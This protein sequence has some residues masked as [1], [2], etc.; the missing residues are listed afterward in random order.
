MVWIPSE[1]FSDPLVD[2]HEGIC[3]QRGMLQR[4]DSPR[5]DG[6]MCRMKSA[7]RKVEFGTAYYPDHWPEAQW[8]RDLDLIQRIGIEVVRFGEFSWS[9][10]EPRPGQ[11]D[12]SG[13]DRFMKLIESRRL[14]LML[15]TPTATLPPW[16]PKLHPDCRLMDVDGH[17]CLSHRHFWCWNHRESRAL[18]ETTIRTLVHRYQDHPS[19]IGYQVDNEPNYAESET[20]YDFNPHALADFRS[21]DGARDWIAAAGHA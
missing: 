17:Y 5:T 6:K 18:A 3:F 14:K 1:L 9:W 13:F 12:F 19:V 10:Y 2:V 15:C 7:E 4:V 11:F 20:I 8:P 21:A 16:L